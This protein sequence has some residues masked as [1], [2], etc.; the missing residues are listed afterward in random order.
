M[1]LKI[2]V[3]DDDPNTLAQLS[4]AFRFE[5]MEAVIADSADK[6]LQ[7]LRDERVDAVVS[8][9]IM[10]GK[11]G[12]ELLETIRREHPELPVI[13]ISGQATIDMAVRAVQNGA[14]DFLE[15]P[16]SA[17]KIILT[18]ENAVRLRRLEVENRELRREV[19]EG[20]MRFVSPAM[21]RVTSQIEM[22]AGTESSVLIHG[23]TGV[24]KELVARAIHQSSGRREGPFVKLNSAAVPAELI[25]SELFGH[26]KGS[27][28]GAI[29]RHVG[30]F[31]AAQGGTL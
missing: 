20:E 26:E 29:S 22:V 2:L 11:T 24:G 18:V 31:E 17:Q 4:R 23:E 5:G 12:I 14:V 13:L 15:K 30:K 7:R 25:E 6:A 19:G 8:D 3:V 21:K 9:V 28:T 1:K 10:P 27:F 16:A